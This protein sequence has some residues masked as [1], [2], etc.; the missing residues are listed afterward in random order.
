MLLIKQV[1]I[2]EDLAEV[3]KPDQSNEK[4][5]LSNIWASLSSK[6]WNQK[7]SP[8][9]ESSA[10][11]EKLNWKI[12]F[13]ER[14]YKLFG[15]KNASTLSSEKWRNSFS[16]TIRSS[17]GAR[18]KSKRINAIFSSKEVA[19]THHWEECFKTYHLLLLQKENIWHN[20][21]HLRKYAVTDIYV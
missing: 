8:N 9:C 7:K 15:T 20:F 18:Q 13:P 4:K 5:C 17:K 10:E 6:C 3:K 19:V 21:L 2:E 16:R 12:V 1:L 14:D 11:A